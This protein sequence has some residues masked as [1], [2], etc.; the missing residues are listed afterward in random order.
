MEMNS[1]NHTI[2]AS[3]YTMTHVD[4]GLCFHLIT[5]CFVLS[6]QVVSD[7]MDKVDL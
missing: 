5:T 6:L 4:N 3:Y 1:T 2:V 7:V